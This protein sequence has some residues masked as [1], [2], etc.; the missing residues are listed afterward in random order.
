M[1]EQADKSNRKQI[2][3][4]VILAISSGREFEKFMDSPIS[5]CVLMNLHL[6]M[7]GA[8]VEKAHSSGKQI[9]LHIDLIKGI[10]ADEAGCEFVC[11]VLGVDGIISTKGKVVET[12]KRLKKIAIL[13][14]FLIDTQSLNKGKKMIGEL[15][16][17]YVEVLPGIACSILPKIK[18]ETGADFLCGGLIDSAEQIAECLKQGAVA[19]TISNREE[20]E[21]FFML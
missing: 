13:R 12:A 2:K 7:V 5:G 14:M 17:D 1:K 4:P 8:F 15:Q 6:S 19:V 11:Q 20:A 16:P 3:E 18:E 21:K 10:T 9:Y